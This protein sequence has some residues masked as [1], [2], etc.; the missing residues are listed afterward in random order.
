[1]IYTNVIE[2]YMELFNLEEILEQSDLTAYDALVLLY[3]GGHIRLPPYLE[4]LVGDYYGQ[5]YE[6]MEK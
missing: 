4:E 2:E 5:E 6:A 3:R 1:M